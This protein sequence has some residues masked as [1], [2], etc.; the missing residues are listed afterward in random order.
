MNK[1]N[2]Y[3]TSNSYSDHHPDNTRA[4]FS[5]YIDQSELTN[6]NNGSIA[7]AVKNIR[8]DN[9]YTTI[10]REYGRPDI[11]IIQDIFMTKKESTKN[12]YTPKFN[13][14]VIKEKI[15]IPDLDK[16][17]DYYLLSKIASSITNETKYAQSNHFDSRQF[18][19]VKLFCAFPDIL[20]VANPTLISVHNIYFTDNT[21]ISNDE[22]ISYLKYAFSTIQYDTTQFSD[23]FL[24]PENKVSNYKESELV[25]KNK[26]SGFLNVFFSPKVTNI[27]GVKDITSLSYQF[28]TNQNEI[29]S[30]YY[31]SKH[32]FITFS[33]ENNNMFSDNEDINYILNKNMNDFGY[34]MIKEDLYVL[35]PN[36]NLNFYKPKILGLKTSL[37]TPDIFN[38]E[39]DTYAAFSNINNTSNGIHAYTISNTTYFLSTVEKLS[40]S[41]FELVDINTQLTLMMDIQVIFR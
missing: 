24:R 20:D 23:T 25:I 36:I 38:G 2:F 21:F 5:T 32:P 8:I 33:S 29:L 41:K 1:Q 9:R 16:G 11:I 6:Y 34:Y 10:P 12:K 3:F 7:L 22:F 27:L 17:I 26:A 37:V 30:Y 4:K 13:F 28:Y 14:E 39:Y 15:Y 35:Y 40:K 19:D 31:H 18:T